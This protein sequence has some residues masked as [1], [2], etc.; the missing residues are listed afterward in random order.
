MPLNPKTTK[1][2][3]KPEKKKMKKSE[4]VIPKEVHFKAS[5]KNA[6]SASSSGSRQGKA[7]KIV[8]LISSAEEQFQ[9]LPITDGNEGENLL[10][11]ELGALSE[12][13]LEKKSFAAAHN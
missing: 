3:Y 13:Y 1:D 8:N 7:S 10:S 2:A 5:K 9:Q 12:A 4:E 6:K 11:R